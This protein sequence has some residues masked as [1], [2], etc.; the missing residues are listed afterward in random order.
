MYNYLK[1]FTDNVVYFHGQRSW[2]HGINVAMHVV[3][4]DTELLLIVDSSSNDFKECKELSERG[5]SIVIL[6]H[7]LISHSNPY[8]KALV[9]PQQEGCEYEN[10]YASGAVV[11]LK[12]CQVLDDSL[13][14]KLSEEF[15]D[16]AGI[17]LQ[18]DMMR[19]DHTAK[20]NRYILSSGLK[21]I[22]NKGL[23]YL[24]KEIGLK[25]EKLSSTD[26]GYSIA[27]C[28]NAS[29]RMDKIE[30]ALELLTTDDDEKCIEISKRIV[31]LN[32]E[33]KEIQRSYYEKFEKEINPDDKCLIVI[34]SSC[35][36]GFRGLISND[37]SN[38]YQRPAM[39]L[40]EVDDLLKGSYRGFDEFDMMSVLRSIPECIYAEGHPFA[41]GICFRIDDFSKFKSNLE[42]RLLSINFDQSLE[43]ALEYDSKEIT[44]ILVKNTEEFYKISGKGFE[45]GLFRVNNLTAINV[46]TLGADKNTLKISCYPSDQLLFMDEEDYHKLKPT[47]VLM[48]FRTSESYFPRALVGKQISVVGTFNHNIFGF[49][50]KTMKTT[51]QIFIED[52]KVVE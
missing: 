44:N 37:F 29:A 11:C 24:I 43:Y 4:K 3:P 16:I 50:K 27:P 9:N 41:G 18:G 39:V 30:I 34:N 38:S 7:H 48:K 23:R 1:N 22:R 49:T 42:E 6:D 26:I 2:S 21:N 13:N 35:G 46:K 32:N 20:E 47:V 28:L 33:R 25:L 52:Y 36:A 51:N 31:E 8:C 45:V 15:L 40:S 17:A 5:M 14:T 10:K 12:M 19:V